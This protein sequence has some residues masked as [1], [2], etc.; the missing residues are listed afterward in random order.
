MR[1]RLDGKVDWEIDAALPS[2]QRASS[3]SPAGS[4][5]TLTARVRYT[6]F[7]TTFYSPSAS[8]V[9]CGGGGVSLLPGAR[10]QGGAAH[11]RRMWEAHHRRGG[12]LLEVR[13]PSSVVGLCRLSHH[14]TRTT[15]HTTHDRK[16]WHPECVICA[17]CNKQI[18]NAR[19]REKNGK[20]VCPTCAV[21]AVQ[22]VVN[23]R[24]RGEDV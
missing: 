15:R 22:S 21:G 18:S 24:V 10:A 20:P 13:L 7:S 1:G 23:A 6:L 12:L 2:P 5:P 11:L 4:P 17:V 14:R 19:P 16:H 9:S 8:A 3:R